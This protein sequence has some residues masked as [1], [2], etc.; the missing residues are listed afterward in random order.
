MEEPRLHRVNWY[1]SKSTKIG[2]NY[3]NLMLKVLR[4]MNKKNDKYILKIYVEDLEKMYQFTD[5]T[6]YQVC[7]I[8]TD[9]KKC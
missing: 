7:E 3:E 9:I 5:L 1:S 8:L 6:L 4:K 2:I